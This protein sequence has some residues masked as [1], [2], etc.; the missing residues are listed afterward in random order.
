[1]PEDPT[2]HFKTLS[3]NS[4]HSLLQGSQHLEATQALE[5][6][7]EGILLKTDEI[8]KNTK[9]KEIQKISIE[10]IEV[11]TLKGDK[12]DTGNIFD[13]LTP[14]QKLSVRGEKGDKGEDS[15]IPGPQG[16]AST[17]PGPQGEAGKNGIDGVNG[18][19]IVGP[20]G[21][22]GLPGASTKGVDGKD[23]TEI[24]PS[25]I[26]EKLHSLPVGSRLDYDKLDNLPN[27][28]SFRRSVSSKSY[29]LSE[30]TDVSM[31]G[32]V[33]GQVLQ[34]DGTRFIPITL[35]SSSTQVFGENLTIQGPGTTF[36]LLHIPV[37]GTVRLYRGGSYQSVANGDYTITGAVI[38]LSPTLVSGET[39]I[40]DYSY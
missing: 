14:E 3:Q 1:M 7:L 6:P 18:K 29:A 28:E 12:G 31:Q 17:V 38:T 27:L 30:M 25:D 4:D 13:E 23:G 35:S 24:E 9:P 34:W 2:T 32:I 8:A 20:Q 21:P 36:T 11:L 37:V 22:Q 19:S 33:V 26:R 5:K 16:E 39:L 40:S 10:G 15:T